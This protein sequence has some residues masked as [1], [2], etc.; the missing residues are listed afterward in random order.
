VPDMVYRV[1]RGSGEQL[2]NVQLHW[3]VD[4]LVRAA[5][6]LDMEALEMELKLPKVKQ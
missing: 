2:V 4:D 1:W 3:S 6:F 5:A